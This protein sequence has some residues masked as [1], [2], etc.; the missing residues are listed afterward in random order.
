MAARKEPEKD[1][2]SRNDPDALHQYLTK[3]VT[4][5]YGVT[6][7]WLGD[8]LDVTDKTLKK[9]NR[10][11]SPEHVTALIAM[12]KKGY[13]TYWRDDIGIGIERAAGL[14]PGTA[15]VTQ[16][17]PTSTDVDPFVASVH[18]S[19]PDR[20]TAPASQQP[21]LTVSIFDSPKPP[22]LCANPPYLAGH[23]RF[24]GRTEQLRFIEEWAG[25]S[26]QQP[27]LLFEAMGGSGKS[28]LAWWWLTERSAKAR[29]DWKGRFWYSFYEVGANT[30]AFV[31]KALAYI[32]GI[33][34]KD[35]QAQSHSELV[36][37]LLSQLRN[38]PWLLVVDG[39]ERLLVRYQ[40]YD[41]ARD[42]DDEPSAN[43]AFSKKHDCSMAR[44]DDVFLF[45][46]ILSA[47][48]SKVLMT[49]RDMPQCFRDDSGQ[50]REGLL[51][52]RLP[53]LS[54]VDAEKLFRHCGVRG[55]S[56]AIRTYLRQNCDC[57]PLVVGLVA[58]LVNHYFSDPGNFDRWVI[59]E[60]GGRALNFASAPLVSRRNHILEA[61]TS[62]LQPKSKAVLTTLSMISVSLSY[63]A[64]LTMVSRGFELPGQGATKDSAYSGPAN[65]LELQGVLLD[66]QARGLVLFDPH[67]RSFD[68]HPVVRRF[69]VDG[70]DAAIRKQVGE[71][72]VD[73]FSATAA[74]PPDEAETLEDVHPQ[75][76]V[77]GALITLGRLDEAWSRLNGDLARALRL[78]IEAMET[79]ISLHRSFFSDYWGQVDGQF[80]D[81]DQGFIFNSAGTV[82]SAANLDVSALQAH[83]G[84]L[85]S[86]IR[87]NDWPS[88]VIELVNISSVLEGLSR[89]RLASKIAKISI[90][91]AEALTDGQLIFISTLEEVK[92]LRSLGHVDEALKRWHEIDLLGR[93][94]EIGLYRPGE[95]ELERLL[96]MFEVSEV[97]DSDLDAVE[98]IAN[99]SLSSRG[100]RRRIHR[101]RG[102]VLMQRGDYLRASEEFRLACELAQSRG[103]SDSSSETKRIL[104]CFL[105][106]LRTG[107]ISLSAAHS[108]AKDDDRDDLA[109]AAL[110]NALEAHEQSA[111]HARRALLQS[112]SDGEPWVRRRT[113]TEARRLLDK[114]CPN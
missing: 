82:L 83:L 61:A 31:L 26:S 75:L 100:A 32:T 36:G 95:A 14:K 48:P 70:L 63:D 7:D 84:S 16:G 47:A 22:A 10:Q 86:S 110:F 17:K 41:A 64:L 53:G 76:T 1:G 44:D 102:E 12:V 80:N 65:E 58:G 78:N 90:Q 45:R 9:L 15:Y 98:A 57:N 60:S 54:A 23:S 91:L 59:A 51:H 109:L 87:S 33:P 29:T 43:G 112:T 114:S 6:L 111:F 25:A 28:I 97:L 39:V 72:V 79:C 71:Q 34:S 46:S 94:W 24:F 105:G 38:G 67:Q 52:Q 81:R 4:G 18:L 99:S 49:S 89:F 20:Q 85:E 77:V 5:R 113:V 107:D 40:R 50:P 96:C 88:I 42:A 62:N 106:G 104:A 30:H 73:Y 3:W 74:C 11:A 93:D 2:T 103:L 35:L 69:A 66:L 68:V 55:D 37:A 27:V 21:R 13:G 92:I 101:L 8:H 108:L 56:A 19:P